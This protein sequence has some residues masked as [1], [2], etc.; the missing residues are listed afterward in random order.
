MCSLHLKLYSFRFFYIFHPFF[1]SFTN[2][3]FFLKYKDKQREKPRKETSVWE[4]LTVLL[5]EWEH[6]NKLIIMITNK[7][8]NINIKWGKTK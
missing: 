5:G 3:L 6:G 2:K 8:E 4:R 7:D 1:T